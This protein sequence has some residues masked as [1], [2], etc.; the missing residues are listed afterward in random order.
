MKLWHESAGAELP[1]SRSGGSRDGAESNFS[2]VPT[3]YFSLL[4]GTQ[5]DMVGPPHRSRVPLVENNF[6]VCTFPRLWSRSGTVFS[7]VGASVSH[8][9]Q[10]FS[11]GDSQDA[12]IGGGRDL[13]LFFPAVR[14]TSTSRINSSYYT[15]TTTTTTTVDSAAAAHKPNGNSSDVK[16]VRTFSM[17]SQFGLVKPRLSVFL[18]LCHIQ[19][20]R[21]GE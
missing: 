8:S 16:S 14:R 2:Y 12:P 6:P 21:L 10:P 15:T 20:A 9:E 4:V 19:D 3:P 5:R 7:C 17:D 11:T 13:Q 1:A 18:L